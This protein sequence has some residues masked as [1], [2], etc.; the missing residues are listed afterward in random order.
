MILVFPFG[1]AVAVAIFLVL[2]RLSI[3]EQ[4]LAQVE[5]ELTEIKAIVRDR[6]EVAASPGDRAAEIAQEDVTHPVAAQPLA[7]AANLSPQPVAVQPALA[8]PVEAPPAPTEEPPTV[9]R[10]GIEVMIGGRLPV[11]IGGVALVLAGFFLV[12]YSIEAGWLGPAARTLIAALFGIALVGGSEI[13]R[14]APATR[15]DARIG[16]VLAGAGVASLYGTLYLA[17][18]LYHLVSPLGGFAGVL[19]VT[20]AALAL[21]LRHGP[22]TAIMALVGGFLAPLVAG[23][24]AAGIGA[25]TVYL[26]LFVTALFG[27]AIH[28]GWGWL[29]LAASIAG[30]GWT[31]FLLAVLTGRASDLTALGLFTML[32]AAGASAALP[33]A[34]VTRG[35][36][37]IAP[38]V[39]GLIQL[40][41]LAP[42]LDFGM[43][44]WSFYLVLAAATLLLAWRVPLY[45]PAV[46]GALALVVVIE[47]VALIG[48]RPGMTLTAT[49]LAALLFGGAGQ[50]LARRDPRWAFVAIGGA[51]GPLV[52]AQALAF[53][54]LGQPGWAALDLIAAIACARIAWVTRASDRASLAQA[55]ALATALAIGLGSGQ[56]LPDAWLSVPIAL[57]MAVLAGWARYRD[58]RALA[59]LPVLAYGVAL[60]AGVVPLA[61]LFAAM[62]RSIE[63]TM[64]VAPL[65]PPAGTMLR[66][67][68][69]PTIVALVMLGDRY[70]RGRAMGVLGPM[71]GVVTLAILYVLAKQV[72]AITT[73]ERFVAWGFAERALFTQVLLGAGWMALRRARAVPLGRALLGL[74]VARV[75][76][77]DLGVAA[78]FWVAQRVGAI[79]LFNLATFHFAAAAAWLWSLRG[80]RPVRIAAAA[81]T[82]A[83]G[84]ATVRQAARGSQMTGP[85]STLEN[86]GYSAILL[87]IAIVWLARGI[88]A[89]ARDLRTMGLVLL[90]AATLKVFLIDAAALDG[91]LRILSFLGLGLALIAI[92]WAYNRFLAAGG[93]SRA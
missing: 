29:A 45:L 75:L 50:W 43:T 93:A 53:E 83:A 90:T 19:A 4:K 88:R 78:P 46:Q 23:F 33:A 77:F 5:V 38:L 52:V 25:L 76:W 31:S 79:P 18:A 26:A 92:G 72:L 85:I 32:L 68:A 13:A 57:A 15:D 28:R 82:L 84:V 71:A 87:A 81:V 7:P 67:L 70:R 24:D 63:G 10:P 11:W 37:R 42:Q 55:A 41:L 39:I 27:L 2:R 1:I 34:G 91:V 73:P 49:P 54:R 51:I 35:A 30:F 40:T 48:G 89:G 80:G 9:T 21:S 3:V 66:S 16:Q 47:G 59:P 8:V 14:R 17:A 60:L 44:P 6:R 20:T 61:A 65:L 86:G 58:E 64:L 22:P 36:I 56:L 74:G 12:R 69:A 62:M